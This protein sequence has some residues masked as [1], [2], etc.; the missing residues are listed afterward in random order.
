MLQSNSRVRFLWLVLLNRIREFRGR[1]P[2]GKQYFNYL[3]SRSRSGDPWDYRHS[4][5]EIEKYLKTLEIARQGFIGSCLEVGC[6][7]GVFSEM[8]APYCDELTAIDI[9]DLAIDSAR[10]RSSCKIEFQV[11]D[12]EHFE[13]NTRFDTIF[14][15]EVLYYLAESS[16][17]IEATV[18][19]LESMLKPGGRIIVVCGNHAF[20]RRNRWEEY[21]LEYGSSFLEPKINKLTS[22]GGREYR[23]S[24]ISSTGSL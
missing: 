10:S 8:L 2:S 19:K 21:F 1:P 18:L 5:Y 14:A 4:P 12:L 11:S 13:A 16:K 24:V 22:E 3:Y 20:D 17:Q 9:S 6:S 15:A 23:V 7:V